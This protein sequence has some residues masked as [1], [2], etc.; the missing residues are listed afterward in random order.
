MLAGM[1]NRFQNSRDRLNRAYTHY[2][3]L[4]LEWHSILDDKSATPVVRK[5]KDTGWGVA[6]AVLTPETIIR[7]QSNKLS[8]IL[9]EIAYQLRA[10]LDGLMWDAITYTQG[11][12]PPSDANGINFP[13]L[14]PGSNFNKCGFHKFPFPESL[15]DWLSG[16]QPDSAMK[17][18]NDPERGLNTTLEDIHNLARLDRHRRLRIIAVVPA[19]SSAEVETEPPGGYIVAHE[20]LDCNLFGGKYDFLRLKVALPGGLIPYKVRLKTS[21]SFEVTAEDIQ[22]Y[23]GDNIGVQI[24]RFIQAVEM[25]LVRFQAEFS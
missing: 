20:W 4:L 24:G 12:E 3:S 22:L 21:L 10:A 25:V 18:L 23:D 14:A 5:E 16:I 15:A 9:G 6:S 1:S 17:P 11:S 19:E 13:I 8:L 7:I 2:Q